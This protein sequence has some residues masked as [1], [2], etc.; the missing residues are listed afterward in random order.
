MNVLNGTWEENCDEGF[1]EFPAKSLKIRVFSSRKT[2]KA[3]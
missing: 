1:P 2:Q 3:K